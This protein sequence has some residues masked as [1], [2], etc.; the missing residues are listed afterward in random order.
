MNLCLGCSWGEILR[1]AHILP[2]MMVVLHTSSWLVVLDR[3][4]KQGLHMLVQKLWRMMILTLFFCAAFMWLC[5]IIKTLMQGKLKQ[6]R[7]RRQKKLRTRHVYGFGYFSF[8]SSLSAK[9]I[10]LLWGPLDPHTLGRK[11]LLLDSCLNIVSCSILWVRSPFFWGTCENI[12]ICPWRFV[13][14]DS[15]TVTCVGLN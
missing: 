8:F 11:E 7:Q 2:R 9:G 1:K 12:W 15:C 3:L 6:K 13:K 14:M 5:A 10:W 4:R